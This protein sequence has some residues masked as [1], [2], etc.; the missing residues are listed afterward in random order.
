MS[1]F[2]TVLILLSHDAGEPLPARSDPTIAE[3]LA[4]L[5]EWGESI[6]SMRI[7]VESWY[8]FGEG[9]SQDV[10]E[11]NR[12][13]VSAY[14]W[15]WNGDG[16][17]RRYSSVR[18]DGKRVSDNLMTF[19]GRRLIDIPNP[20]GDPPS[21]IAKVRI[22]HSNTHLTG[23]MPFHGLG[24]VS[25]DQFI[26]N[27]DRVGTGP[28]RALTGELFNDRETIR[29]RIRRSAPRL[30]EHTTWWTLDPDRHYLPVVRET[31][32]FRR[33]SRTHTYRTTSRFTAFRFIESPG[34]WFPIKGDRTVFI[35]GKLHERYHWRFTDVELN[36]RYETA[37]FRPKI[38]EDAEV[39]D[40]RQ[41]FPDD[42]AESPPN[43]PAWVLWLVGSAFGVAAVLML[44]RTW[45][46]FRGSTGS[47]ES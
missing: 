10:R 46:L 12:N 5:K 33:G 20:E 25:D 31:A 28:N 15:I 13:V 37:L 27:W 16:R 45:R 30:A 4:S 40:E 22:M 41:S 32:T 47:S 21:K 24:F 26:W 34:V 6:T 18:R 44:L 38:P 36:H 8:E 39:E 11:R 7:R 19:D 14:D 42:S 3:V 43:E 17:M 9:Y 2:A 35:D 29:L 1:A 23:I